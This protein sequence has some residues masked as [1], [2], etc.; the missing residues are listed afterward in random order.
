MKI[1]FM[2]SSP[3]AAVR[4]TIIV[5]QSSPSPL[6]T[7]RGSCAP[8]LAKQAK[9]IPVSAHNN[10]PSPTQPVAV[11]T[12]PCPPNVDVSHRDNNGKLFISILDELYICMS[13]QLI[14]IR[15]NHRVKKVLKFTEN[16]CDC[17]NFKIKPN[18][19]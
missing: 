9:I 3:K 7:G 2:F 5:K 6:A 19:G 1:V 14:I 17:Y 4:P 10:I 11:V 13:M 18:I 15:E 12:Q 8:P 16:I